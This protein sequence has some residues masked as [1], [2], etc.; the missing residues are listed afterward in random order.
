MPF[1]KKINQN[2][3]GVVSI[4]TSSLYVKEKPWSKLI[5]ANS[6]QERISVLYCH[7]NVNFLIS[8]FTSSKFGFGYKH[9]CERPK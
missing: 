8:K 1:L 3:N 2:L 5:T 4:P 7:C 6:P 9:L